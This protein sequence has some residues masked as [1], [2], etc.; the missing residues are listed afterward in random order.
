MFWADNFCAK[1]FLVCKRILKIGY[2]FANTKYNALFTEFFFLLCHVHSNQC[3]MEFPIWFSVSYLPICLFTSTVCCLFLLVS[4][5]YNFFLVCI[6][7]ASVVVFVIF[8]LILMV[9]WSVHLM[10]SWHK[11]TCLY[12]NVWAYFCFACLLVF[13]LV[14]CISVVF[15]SKHYAHHSIR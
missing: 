5:I 10:V 14:R 6:V 12:T 13:L 7:V 15:A 3:F 8:P 9:S 4:Y 1:C 2:L 11:F